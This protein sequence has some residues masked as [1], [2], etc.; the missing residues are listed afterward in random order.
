MKAVLWLMALLAGEIVAAESGAPVQ[1][2]PV[3]VAAI[4]A[5]AEVRMVYQRSNDDPRI[6]FLR[7]ESVREKSAAARAGLEKGMEIVA[8]QGVALHGLSEEDYQRVM[9][10]PVAETLTL[11]V[12]RA[13]RVRAEELRIAVAK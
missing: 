5:S 8:I 9:R 7:V 13:G 6:S 3:R 10:T 11:R 1:L 12:R 4:W 2:E